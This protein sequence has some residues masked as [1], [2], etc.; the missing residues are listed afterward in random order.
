MARDPIGNV[1]L[2]GYT[3]STNFPVTPGSF[4]DTALAGAGF[5]AK[6][7][8]PLITEAYIKNQ[9]VIVRGQY[10]DPEAV[11]LLDGIQQRTKTKESATT[12]TLVGKRLA[13]MI[14]VGMT[15]VLRVRNSD[16]TLSPEFQFA[17]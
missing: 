15:V 10:F 6:L 1:Y 4:Q 8:A 2:V 14:P 13:D 16:G 12:P 5:V 3:T 7:A 9:D 11:I 17:R